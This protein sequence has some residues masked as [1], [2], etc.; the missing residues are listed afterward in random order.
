M[1]TDTQ[2]RHSLEQFIANYGPPY[3]MRS[4]NPKIETIKQWKDIYMRCNISPNTTDTY[5]TCKNP[6]DSII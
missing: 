5:H 4:D 2:G 3:H 6:A 1:E